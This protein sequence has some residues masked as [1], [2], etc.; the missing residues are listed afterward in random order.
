MS[1]EFRSGNMRRSED[2]L[3][4]RCTRCNDWWPADGEF[5]YSNPRHVAGLAD[6]CKACY[7]EHRRGVE[8]QN[9]AASR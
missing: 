1:G 7:S 5:F 8:F 4:K 9:A 2:G 6:W 3:E